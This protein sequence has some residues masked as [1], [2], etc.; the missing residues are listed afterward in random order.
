[1]LFWLAQTQDSSPQNAPAHDTHRKSIKRKDRGQLLGMYL[2]DM[3]FFTDCCFAQQ[4]TK[5]P[6]VYTSKWTM[7]MN[8]LLGYGPKSPA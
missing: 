1:M 3:L 8:L 2:H 6:Q 4:K 7:D 5:R